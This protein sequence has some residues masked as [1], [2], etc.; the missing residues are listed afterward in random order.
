MMG[1]DK[2]FD[3]E[4]PLFLISGL[5]LNPARKKASGPAGDVYL[6]ERDPPVILHE[7]SGLQLAQIL[8]ELFSPDSSIVT[9]SSLS[10]IKSCICM[11]KP[12]TPYEFRQK[13]SR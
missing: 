10:P 5:A 11:V 2:L 1:G 4:A 13:V 3:P 7:F 6:G 12:A 9:I 8:A